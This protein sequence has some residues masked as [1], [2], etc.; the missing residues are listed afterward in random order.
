MIDA[1][2]KNAV[3]KVI[4]SKNLS[5]FVA[6]N[7]KNF[8]GGKYVQTFEKKL[9]KLTFGELTNIIF[10]KKGWI[11]FENI[12]KEV[13]ALN[14]FLLRKPSCNNFFKLFVVQ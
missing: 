4:K 14:V 1:K 3:D 11:A 12:F 7:S 2:E 5:G 8:Y 10:S 9:E 13:V 6:R